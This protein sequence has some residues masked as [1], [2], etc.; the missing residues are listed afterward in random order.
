MYTRKVKNG[1]FIVSVSYDKPLTEHKSAQCG[2]RDFFDYI[3]FVSYTTPVITIRNNGWLYCSG[4]YSRTTAKQMG[5]FLKE[6]APGFSYHDIKKLYLDG[7]GVNIFTG[8][9]KDMT[10][11]F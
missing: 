3:E 8:E 4:L 11:L 7:K 1:Y 5:W 9:V 2:I 6:Y 10:E